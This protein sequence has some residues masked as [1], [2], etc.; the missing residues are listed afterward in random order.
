MQQHIHRKL[1]KSLDALLECPG[2]YCK[3]LQVRSPHLENIVKAFSSLAYW[4]M[5]FAPSRHL[6]VQCLKMDLHLS[7]VYSLARKHNAVHTW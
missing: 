6:E 7:N 2:L 1:Q 4:K 5:V 3:C